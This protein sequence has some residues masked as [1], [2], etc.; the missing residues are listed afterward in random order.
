MQTRPVSALI[1]TA[2]EAL[3]DDSD[4]EIY[5]TQKKE[6]KRYTHWKESVL[7]TTMFRELIKRLQAFGLIQLSVESGKIT[8]NQFLRLNFT[9]DELRSGFEYD[10]IYQ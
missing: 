9:L 4:D 3:S 5:G 8:E 7:T 1:E 6:L 10:E 2:Q